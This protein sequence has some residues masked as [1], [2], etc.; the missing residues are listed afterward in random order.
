MMKELN[1][2]YKYGFETLIETEEFPKGLNEEIIR[3]L[4]AKKKEPQWLLN[5]R[6]KAFKH[7]NSL[8]P[9]E[10]AYLD[11][12]EIDFQ[13]LLYYSAPKQKK[14]AEQPHSLDDIDPELLATFEKLGIPLAEQK[15]LAGVAVD[16]VFD[17]VSVG[18]THQKQLE[19]QGIIFC[20]ISEAVRD[21]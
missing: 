1:E 20:S 13:D 19:E 12:P 21:Y 16:A 2:D 17:S 10:W 4:S 18:T 8:K 11:Y 3:A 7:W 15:Q 6:L 9:P 14:E 5:Y